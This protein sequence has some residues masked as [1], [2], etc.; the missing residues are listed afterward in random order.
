MK[1][2]QPISRQ[3]FFSFIIFSIVNW[4]RLL[5]DKWIN[6]SDKLKKLT[7]SL[8]DKLEKT[9]EPQTDV[10]V[11]NKE[12]FFVIV[13]EDW[14][15]LLDAVSSVIHDKGYNI[16]RIFATTLEPTSYA[17]ILL[18]IYDVKR[19][20]DILKDRQTMIEL[21]RTAAKGG[22]GLKSLISISGVKIRKYKEILD[23]IMESVPKNEWKYLLGEEG[24]VIKFVRSRTEAYLEERDAKT[25]AEI[26]VWQNR[27][28]RE[29]KEDPSKV[30]TFIHNFITT[31]GLR[32][33]GITV[34]G[35]D[36]YVSLDSV[37]S[38]LSEEGINKVYEKEFIYPE[39]ISVVR[40]E[41]L[42]VPIG[43]L[44]R[45]ARYLEDTLNKPKQR[46]FVDIK[47]GLEIIGR[48]IVPRLIDEYT[49][50]GINQLLIFPEE[51]DPQRPILRVILVGE[52]SED[53]TMKLT[54]KFTNKGFTF[55]SPKITTKKNRDKKVNIL[56]FQTSPNMLMFNNQEEVYRTIKDIIREFVP[57]LRDFD[58]SL[59]RLS[60]MKLD[61][62]YATLDNVPR[63]IIR[64]IFYSLEDSFRLAAN[65][66]KLAKIISLTYSSVEN[67]LEEESRG[68]KTFKDESG[69][70]CVLLAEDENQITP[71]IIGR[72]IYENFKVVATVEILGVF[73][74]ICV[75]S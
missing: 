21:L 22:V 9:K 15:G 65:D 51:N 71:Y 63:K 8:L 37:L 20:K 23:E 29:V 73:S 5:E 61:K 45:I 31:K 49:N 56:I 70:I 35:L 50:T 3:N 54:E 57:S 68:L 66:K 53:I 75:K 25:L 24:E 28:Y 52:F 58:E 46:R 33:S 43:K 1:F 47:F 55:Q 62:L 10:F 18:S 16:N 42:E 13:A 34:V 38:V 74:V 6:L 39:G 26:I 60:V 12:V 19:G 30:K 67:Y 17:F 44:S 11:D 48:V 27:L 64:R 40:V 14:A 36:R 2:L 69:E 59:R 4:E 7:Y 72:E 41:T 32:M